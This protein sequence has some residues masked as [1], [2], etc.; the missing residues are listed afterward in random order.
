M[1]KLYFKILNDEEVVETIKEF[2]KVSFH[3]FGFSKELDRVFGF[4]FQNE[5]DCEKALTAARAKKLCLWK[6]K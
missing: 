3:G 5:S 4:H 6:V 2:Q 1:T